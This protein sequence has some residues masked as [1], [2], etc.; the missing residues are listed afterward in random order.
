VV[1]SIVSII[2]ERKLIPGLTFFGWEQQT[3]IPGLVCAFIAY[4]ICTL[5]WPSKRETCE[6]PPEQV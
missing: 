5:V 6:L 3:V 1:G 4:M 2:Y